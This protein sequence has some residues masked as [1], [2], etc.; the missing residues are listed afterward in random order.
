MKC[1]SDPSTN[2]NLSKITDRTVEYQCYLCKQICSNLAGLL[3]HCGRTHV[4]AKKKSIRK[5]KAHRC[6]HCDTIFNSNVQLMR[7]WETLKNGKSSLCTVCFATFDKKY[8]LIVHKAMSGACSVSKF[9]CYHCGKYYGNNTLLKYHLVSVHS[10]VKSFT[11]RF[12]SK[13]FSTKGGLDR[14]EAAH[15][16]KRQFVCNVNG[17]GRN[18]NNTGMLREHTRFIHEAPK[19][20]CSYCG[21]IFKRPVT[22]R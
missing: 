10:D 9:L 19:Q 20:K 17:C 11:C 1:T 7:H 5:F 4:A 22:L 18:F 3:A 21:K 13:T 12:C 16:N 6:N 8:D 2:T 15:E 14:H